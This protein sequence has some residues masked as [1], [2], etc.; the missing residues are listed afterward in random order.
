[1]NKVKFLSLFFPLFILLTGCS[2]SLTPISQVNTGKRADEF[3]IDNN[4]A[5]VIDNSNGL[6]FIDITKPLSPEIVGTYNNYDYLNAI[7]VE[8]DI[9]YITIG[10]GLVILDITHPQNPIEIS[11]LRLGSGSY[12]CIYVKD[13]YAYI[14][15]NN[16][17]DF[18]IVDISDLSSPKRLGTFVED[19]YMYETRIYDI[20]VKDNLAYLAYN[21]MGLFIL[22]VSD[23]NN[24][25]KIS[26][27]DVTGNSTHLHLYKD[28]IILSSGMG[29]F[30]IFDVS[31][32]SV[33][34]LE[35][36]VKISTNY[37]IRGSKVIKDKLFV[38]E[39]NN[40]FIYDITNINKPKE[41][42]RFKEEKG[43]YKNFEV[44]NDY[45]YLLHNYNDITYLSTIK[46]D[47]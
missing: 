45:I 46:N 35:S 28:Y 38:L 29:G 3:V 8:K 40:L 42:K 13:N 34:R 18:V 27:Y 6:V 25:K 43:L 44:T 14:G 7:Y 39:S 24:P 2:S 10:G 31:L 37:W 23:A 33:P 1:M 16:G 22:D 4:Y 11:K 36:S 12:A 20:F 15:G 47:F 26:S 19:L 21:T 9:A 32:P 5:Y 17:P 41:I 30:Q